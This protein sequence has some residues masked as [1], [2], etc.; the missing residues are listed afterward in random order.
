M[1][2]FNSDNHYVYYCGARILWKKRNS[3]QTQ[4]ESEMQYFGAILKMKE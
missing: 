1:S 2:E 4:Q 3:P